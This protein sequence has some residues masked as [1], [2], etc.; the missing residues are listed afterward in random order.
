MERK[1][2][3]FINKIF[4]PAAGALILASAFLH[5]HE[6]AAQSVE[7]A[8]NESSASGLIV[9]DGSIKATIICA[10]EYERLQIIFHSPS[11]AT[12]NDHPIDIHRN[13]IIVIGDPTTH[14]SSLYL[15]TSDF[16]ANQLN[17]SLPSVDRK[18]A[19]WPTIGSN[20]GYQPG[21]KYSNFKH[22]PRMDVDTA[23]MESCYSSTLS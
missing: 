10:R 5:P 1:A 19:I 20:L 16:Q 22:Y 12:L 6:A 8:T 15:K 2:E 7:L 18:R 14:L 13:L 11:E 17:T 21:V 4:S 9:S 3:R 23:V